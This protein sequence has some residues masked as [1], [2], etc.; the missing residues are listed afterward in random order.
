[1]NPADSSA[2][3]ECFAAA[4]IE[5]TGSLRLRRRSAA[6]STMSRSAQAG[7]GEDRVVP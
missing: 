2:W 7:C 1:V 6:K 3:L 4:A 5:D